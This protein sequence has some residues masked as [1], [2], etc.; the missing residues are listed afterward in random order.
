MVR[1]CPVNYVE[2]KIIA[3][4]SK[5]KP[6]FLAYGAANIYAIGGKAYYQVTKTKFMRAPE[7]DFMIKKKR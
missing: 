6:R 3:P 5:I 4:K 1:G 7:R 2:T